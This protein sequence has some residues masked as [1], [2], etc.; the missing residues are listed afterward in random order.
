M[1]P[2]HTLLT[3]WPGRIPLGADIMRTG[4]RKEDICSKI[5]TDF[6]LL[7]ALHAIHIPH[8][9]ATFCT[10]CSHS[11]AASLSSVVARLGIGAVA[12]VAVAAGSRALVDSTTANI[13]M[14]IAMLRTTSRTVCLISRHANYTYL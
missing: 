14:T 4:H 7:L 1:Q 3:H 9:T 6:D 13:T 8:V 2:E 5:Y 11:P 10:Q 12:V